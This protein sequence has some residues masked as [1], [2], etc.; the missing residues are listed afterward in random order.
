MNRRNFLK[1][2]LLFSV[3]T[4]FLLQEHTA[5]IASY[6]HAETPLSYSLGRVLFDDVPVYA[7]PDNNSE[8]V[9]RLLFNQVVEYQP[10]TQIH[11]IE[12]GNWFK[13]KEEG[14]I[15]SRFLQSVE[16]QLNMPALEIPSSG[17]LAQVTVP[18][19]QAFVK[20]KGNIH[21]SIQ[22]Q[23]FYY[24]STHWVYSIYQDAEGK[25]FYLIKEDRWNDAYYV[26]AEHL[27]LISDHELKSQSSEIDPQQKV[28]RINL[29]DQNLVA[30][31]NEEPVFQ[32]TLSSGAKIGGRDLSTPRGDYFIHYK[33][34]ARHMVHADSLY[35]HDRDLFG[36]PW[37]SYF[38]NS[39]I[40]FHG[41]YWHN[42][43][44]QPI[45]HGCI[46]LP[47]HAARWIY[48]WSQP[49]VPPRVKTY[50]SNQGTRVE[51]R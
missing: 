7:H 48:L 36:V 12:T 51:V 21:N 22:D 8:I 13:L 29:Q 23:I 42:D 35:L 40:A 49:V 2:S 26:E 33:R 47:I 25:Y 46:N 32:S 15:P 41:T 16:H 43:F 50:R 39:G 38:T 11:A 4:I 17:Q 30:Y 6:L 37:V 9:E 18:F 31:E 27:H 28:I 24:G 45:S 10:N 19:T 34:A 20:K 5:R 44:G 14:F 1:Y 3:N